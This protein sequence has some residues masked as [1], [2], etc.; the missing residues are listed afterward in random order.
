MVIWLETTVL[1]INTSTSWTPYC[2][3]W[4][5]GGLPSYQPT[6]IAFTS[7]SPHYSITGSP[8]PDSVFQEQ[9]KG[10]N[11][12]RQ[13]LLQALKF[14]VMMKTKAESNIQEEG[15]CNSNQE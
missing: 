7:I 8:H 5:P 3:Q 4:L 6:I 10:H 2:N 9:E 15:S 13:E 11:N 12:E 14:L 1:F